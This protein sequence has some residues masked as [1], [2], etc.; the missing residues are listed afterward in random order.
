[1]HRTRKIKSAATGYCAER[2]WGEGGGSVTTAM[3]FGTCQIRADP[4]SFIGENYDTSCSYV[5][6]LIF[7]QLPFYGQI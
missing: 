4:M 5:L 2:C 1:M 3:P 7:I 6:Y